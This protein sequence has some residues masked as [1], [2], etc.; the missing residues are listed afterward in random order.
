MSTIYL[1][2]TPIDH[3]WRVEWEDRVLH[4]PNEVQY[5]GSCHVRAPKW[6][7]H[8]NVLHI[9]V[10]HGYRMCQSP[11]ARDRPSLPTPSLP[12]LFR[13]P[14][15]PWNSIFGVAVNVGSSFTSLENMTQS[16]AIFASQ[17][18]EVESSSD[19]LHREDSYNMFYFAN[20]AH[21]NDKSLDFPSNIRK[22]SFHMWK[23]RCVQKCTDV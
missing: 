20:L 16:L 4:V 14:A 15:A 17:G 13:V 3:V 5:A 22:C 1:T 7:Y 23:S 18:V 21:L 10:F 19:S 12:P 6:S 11:G 2:L 8:L 9:H